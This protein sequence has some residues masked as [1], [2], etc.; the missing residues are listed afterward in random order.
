MLVARDE[1]KTFH[2]NFKLLQF[3]VVSVEQSQLHFNSELECLAGLKL[4]TYERL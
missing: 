4:V 2:S 1:I 3:T